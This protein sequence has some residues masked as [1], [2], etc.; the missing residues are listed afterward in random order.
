MLGHVLALKVFHPEA[1][2]ISSFPRPK[3]VI[4]LCL[5]LRGRKSLIPE[6]GG[7]ELLVNSSVTTTDNHYLAFTSQQIWSLRSICMFICFC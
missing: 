7:P 6:G 2:H 5:T 3:Q 1:T 4:R